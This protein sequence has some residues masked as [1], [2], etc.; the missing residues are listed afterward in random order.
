MSLLAAALLG[1]IPGVARSDCSL[2]FT[3]NIPLPDLGAAFYQ[4]YQAGLYPNGSNI[5]PAGHL[6]AGFAQ[7]APTFSAVGS[8]ATQVLV[9]VSQV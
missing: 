5:M 2:V 6:E 7:A 8:A 9:G 1:M 3:G 4:G